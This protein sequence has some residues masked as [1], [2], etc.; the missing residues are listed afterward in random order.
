MQFGGAK[1]SAMMTC[2]IGG[3]SSVVRFEAVSLHAHYPCYFSLIHLEKC[4]YLPDQ[5]GL[6]IFAMENQFYH[7]MFR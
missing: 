5:T 1:P 4:E 7:S 3:I 2:S 6:C